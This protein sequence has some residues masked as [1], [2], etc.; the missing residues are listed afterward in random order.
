MQ[1]E[2]AEREGE[3]ARS[4]EKA[5]EEVVEE[6]K[7]APVPEHVV[8]VVKPAEPQRTATVAP[9]APRKLVVRVSDADEVVWSDVSSFRN[10]KFL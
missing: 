10:S 7:Q 6:K 4:E 5:A 3:P 9:A 2:G 1:E 8:D